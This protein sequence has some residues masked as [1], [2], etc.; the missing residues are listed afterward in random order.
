ADGKQWGRLV[1]S[2]IGAHLINAQLQGVCSVYYWRDGNDEVDFVV[3]SRGKITAIEV[4]SG[5]APRVHRGLAAFERAFKPDRLLLVGGDGISVATF[6][7]KP[8][9]HW[10]R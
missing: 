4:K 7:S 1:E 6:L 8:V 3:E 5:S 10:V 2:S 9:E